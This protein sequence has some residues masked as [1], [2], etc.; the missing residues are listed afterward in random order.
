[1]ETAVTTAEPTRTVPASSLADC[2]A[3]LLSFAVTV[4]RSP[5]LGEAEPIRR[6][7]L[8]QIERAEA[9][10]RENGIEPQ[11]VEAARFAIA[12]L[13]DEAILASPWPGRSAWLGNPFQWQLYQI[14]DAGEQFFRRLD[15]LRADAGKSR[16]VLG[17]YLACLAMGYEGKYKI[18][19]REELDRLIRSLARDAGGSGLSA[20]SPSWKRPDDA[21]E[22]PGEA[23]PVW[24]TALVIA[25][26]AV[27]LLV[28]F[29]LVSRLS[30]DRV[31]DRIANT[32]AVFAR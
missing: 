10:A 32:L 11:Q 12:A 25:A 7:L 28:I 30:A 22:L 9:C 20:L 3:E 2:Y 23:I 17:V 15:A 29:S 19:G 8:E 6:R 26:A 4:R 31:A 1:M 5:D 18:E 16:P 27:L 13:L 14:R 21:P 24:I